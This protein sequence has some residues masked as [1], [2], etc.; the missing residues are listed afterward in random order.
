M[1]SCEARVSREIIIL[2]LSKKVLYFGKGR[3]LLLPVKDSLEKCAVSRVSGFY[4]QMSLSWVSWPYTFPIRA[5]T[6][7]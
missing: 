4:T 6:R 2:P 5:S 7:T 3:V 1:S